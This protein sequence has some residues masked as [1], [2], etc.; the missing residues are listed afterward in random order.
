[1]TF[2]APFVLLGLAL[3]PGLYFLVRLTP[4]APRRI[5]FPPLA[6]LR[7]LPVAERTPSRMPFWLLLL[8]LAVAALVIIG[9]AGPGLHP[10]PA[11]PGSGP[12]LLV[13]D[14]GWAAAPHWPRMLDAARRIVAA[15]NRADRG[16]ALLATARGPDN[17]AP[18]IQGVMTAHQAGEVLNAL[19]PE[20]WPAD[21]AGAATALAGA[22]LR[23]RIYLADGITDGPGFTRFLATLRPARILAP[24]TPPPL[25]LPPTRDAEGRLIAH[26]TPPGLNMA[27]PP[28]A[29]LAEQPGG[30]ALARAV[31]RRDG[32]ATIDLPLPLANRVTRLVLDGPP[33]A[34]G[35]YLLDAGQKARLIGLASGSGAP[36]TPFL[37]PLYFL[38]RALPPGSQTV[39]GDLA[40]LLA[41]K[42]DV[43]ILAD[44]PLAP[45]EQRA[46]EAWIAAGGVLIRFVGPLTAAAPDPLTPDPLLP[47]DRRLGGAL[48][49]TAPQHLAPFPGDSPLAGLSADSQTTVSRQILADPTQLDPAT[50]WASLADGTPLVLGKPLGKGLLI[51]ILTTAN[52]D[53]SNLALAPLYPALLERLAGL[54]HGAGLQ[55]GRALPIAAALNA[56]GALVPP[57]P[58][59]APALTPAAL[60]RARLS[61]IQPPGLYG[62]LYGS[63]EGGVALNLGGHV[64]VPEAAPLA[65]AEPLG[66]G[67]A[68]VDLGSLFLAAALPL[69]V[70]DLLLSLWLRGLLSRMGRPSR[71]AEAGLVLAVACLG[72]ALLSGGPA[73]AQQMPAQ[74]PAPPAI[75][76]AIPPGALQTEL[77]YVETNDPATDR[78]AA[79]A[80]KYLSALVSARS[81]ALLGDPASVSPGSDDIALYPLLYWLIPSA[82]PPPSPAACAAL[83]RYMR[84]GGLLLLDT[85]GS[86]PGGPG[87][88]A[89]FAPGAGAAL[90]RAAACLTLPPL[91]PLT[92]ANAIAHSFYILQSFP[93]K[94]TGAPVLIA[95]AAARDA[96]G[97]TPIIIGQNDWAGAWARDA[98]GTPEELPLPGGDDQRVTAD[99]FGVNLVIYALTGD[100]KAD[101]SRLPGFLEPPQR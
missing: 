16:L 37:G 8:R 89:G 60:R 18:A 3:L 96:D 49:W 12:V 54:A 79:D 11:L 57:A 65:G 25:L 42:A 101:Q 30:G 15:A 64:P 28:L 87:S 10:P 1:M 78:L 86:D 70:L 14:N 73:H 97:V 34:G 24:E 27:R 4:P 32:S 85:E 91:E 98:T 41:D 63:G 81:S 90:Q 6:L 52:A 29:V 56:F 66:A 93:G 40:A 95:S 7:G 44:V 76:P 38:K 43:V 51:C 9:L 88:G 59:T 77:A 92:T 100:Y 23:T 67:P 75:P 50:V 36:E 21:R 68:P 47:G 22:T 17:A 5:A 2:A 20:P 83:N 55:P 48:T 39:T 80:M 72:A 61:P 94:F 99:H 71:R 84:H 53:W 33:S 46:A 69:L 26:V 35:V 58:G 19:T 13:I 74:M 82:A 31:F 62:G 45:T